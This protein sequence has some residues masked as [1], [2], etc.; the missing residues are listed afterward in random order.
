MSYN[1]LQRSIEDDT[2]VFR[3]LVALESLNLAYNKIETIHA[4]VLYPLSSLMSLDLSGNN[5]KTLPQNPFKNMIQLSNLYLNTSSLVCD[6][7][8]AWLPQWLATQSFNSVKSSCGYPEK[9]KGSSIFRLEAK[10]FVCDVP[11]QPVIAEFPK[12]QTALYG[13]NMTLECVAYTGGEKPVFTWTKDQNVVEPF[14]VKTFMNVEEEKDGKTMYKV[15]SRLFIDNVT[16]FHGGTYQCIARNSFGPS[17]SP[18]THIV[19]NRFPYFTEK[20][21]SVE[22]KEGG[23]VEIRCAAAGHPEPEIR[24]NKEGDFPAP[25]EKRLSYNSNTYIIKPV[26]ARDSGTYICSAWNKAGSVNLTARVSVIFPPSFERPLYNQEAALNQSIALECQVRLWRTA[27]RCRTLHRN[28]KD[29]LS[30]FFKL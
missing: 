14:R 28:P 16:H 5:L 9:L 17:Y 13:H 26:R 11:P 8:L 21:V 4:E 19:V 22:V 30:P 7:H 12:N 3:H 29:K 2:G 25:R 27:Y 1:Q 23:V 6:C 15:V 10:D 20:P 18:P 24:L